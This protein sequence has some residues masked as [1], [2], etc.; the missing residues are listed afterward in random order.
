MTLLDGIVSGCSFPEVG[1]GTINTI[2][3]AR[4]LDHYSREVAPD[5]FSREQQQA[6]SG[7]GR[8]ESIANLTRGGGW[9]D[10]RIFCPDRLPASL[11]YHP[12]T[13]P[14]GA[15]CDVYDHTVNVYGRDPQTGFARRPLDNTGIQ[16]GLGALRDKA[17]TVEQ[18]LDLNERIGGFDADANHVPERTRADL[19]ATRAASRSGR[20]LKAG[21]G[22]ACM[23][24]I[25]YRAYTD[26][27][28]G[29]DI[30]MRFQSFSTR[31]RLLKVNGTYGN[32]VMLVEDNRYGGF[33]LD[34]PVILDALTQMDRWLTAIAAD[35]RPG[36]PTDR[37]VRNKTGRAHGRLLE[38]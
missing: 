5:A 13:N 36:R 2:T 16:Y 7:F 30:H 17:I 10:P 8:W 37:V 29:G 31:E 12:E 1:F 35:R 14:T 22:L 18:F 20:L 28:P 11:R 38:P 21:A 26:D 33:S 32:Q 24:M 23:P 19:S 25:D 9:I 27:A 6:V 15:R 3:D 4:L 34:S